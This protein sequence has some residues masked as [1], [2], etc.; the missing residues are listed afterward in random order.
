MLRP[1]FNLV[2][3]SFLLCC[4]GTV[5]RIHHL[6]GYSVAAEYPCETSVHLPPQPLLFTLA[7]FVHCETIYLLLPPPVALVQSN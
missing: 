5:Q 1:K 3:S 7:D 2:N 6:D 4:G